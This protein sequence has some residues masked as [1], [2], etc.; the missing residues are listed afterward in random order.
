MIPFQVV[1]LDPA[2]F[3]PLYG[4]DSRALAGHGAEAQRVDRS[5][6][7]PCR[8]SLADAALG[9][10]VLLLSH[11]HLAGATPY[12]ARHAIFVRD[13]AERATPAVGEWPEVLARRLLSVRAFD[14]RDRLVAADVTG[15][16]QAPALVEWLLGQAAVRFLHVHNAR[17]GC[18]LARVERA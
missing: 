4:L 18:Y 11:E 9:E 14:A 1:A 10:T 5:P 8:V 12:R 3:R 16:R 13:G 2:P 15:G 6:G 17:H 7:F